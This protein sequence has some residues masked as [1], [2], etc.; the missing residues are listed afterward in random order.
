MVFNFRTLVATTFLAAAFITQA[1]AAPTQYAQATG[2]DSSAP[3]AATTVTPTLTPTHRGHPA[4]MRA[5]TVDEWIQDLHK[6]LH[7]TAAQ[8]PQ[9]NAVAQVMRENAAA[10]DV[11]VRAR[12]QNAKTMNAVDDLRS[13]EQIAEAHEAGLHKLIPAFQTLYDGMSDQQK[14]TVDAV[15]QRGERRATSG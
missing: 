8:E 13:Y 1:H 3:P 6:R 10:L 11:A 2:A 15:F 7:I 12:V 14:K 5:A 9:W 4:R